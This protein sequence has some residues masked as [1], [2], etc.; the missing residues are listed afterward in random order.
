M[1]NISDD[2]KKDLIHKL[3]I[4]LNIIYIN[5]HMEE[6]I[7]KVLLQEKIPGTD[8]GFPLSKSYSMKLDCHVDRSS[9]NSHSTYFL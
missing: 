3:Y 4:L 7:M 1:I 8:K 5:K 2:E 9:N 6:D